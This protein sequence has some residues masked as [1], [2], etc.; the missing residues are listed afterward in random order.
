MSAGAA[1]AAAAAAVRQAIKACGVLVRVE[2]DE[3]L[4]VLER[5][6]DGLVVQATGGFFSKNYQYLTSYKGLAFHTKSPTELALP[7]N[8]EIVT[9][10]SIS[11][12]G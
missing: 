5:Q 2:P 10:G 4:R 6:S 1:A 3:F 8:C 12:P 7:R 9:A 11:I